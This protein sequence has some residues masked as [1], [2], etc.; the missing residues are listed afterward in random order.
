M[1]R[2]K[3]LFIF[4]T[5]F[6]YHITSIVSWCSYIRCRSRVSF[7]ATTKIFMNIRDPRSHK[8]YWTSGWNKTWKKIQARTG[9]EP[10][11][12]SIPV[13]RS[14]NLANKPT[15]SWLLSW[16]QITSQV[17]N[18]DCRYMKII[19][20]H[21]GEETNIRDPRSYKHY[22]TSSWL[23]EKNPLLQKCLPFEG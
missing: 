13:Q 1:S 23:F 6:L 8:H 4:C 9:F 7:T 5:I 22:W 18:N 2:L 12:S 17:M 3:F 15:G 10:M 16:V 19:Y 21:C 20:V 14:T 11:T